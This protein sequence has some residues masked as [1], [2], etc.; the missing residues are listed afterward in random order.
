M[1]LPAYK[2]F[3][4]PERRAAAWSALNA[5]AGTLTACKAAFTRVDTATPGDCFGYIVNAATPRVSYYA[6]RVNGALVWRRHW[7]Q[8]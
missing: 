1:P 8:W 6:A 2:L 3:A 7:W 5:A 4:G